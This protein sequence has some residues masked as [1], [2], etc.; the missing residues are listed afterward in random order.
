[1]KIKDLIK[2][3][4]DQ[5]VVVP[6]F[7]REYVWT[8]DQ[9]KLLLD[10]LYRD[11]TIGSILI[12]DG[13][14]ELARKRVGGS[15]NELQFPEGKDEKV[16]YIL[17]GQQRIT[18]LLFAFAKDCKVFKTGKKKEEKVKIYINTEG[19][20]GAKIIKIFMRGSFLMIKIWICQM[21]TW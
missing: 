16:V 9:M 14:D 2:K 4:S 3:A 19:L 13:K 17:D 8:R 12:W 21:G 5:E 7:Q 1:M 6:E 15:L 11:Y 20:G 18:S 10:S